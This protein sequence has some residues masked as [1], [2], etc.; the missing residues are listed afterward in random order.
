MFNPVQVLLYNFFSDSPAEDLWR[1]TSSYSEEDIAAYYADATVAASGV[2]KYDWESPMLTE[3]RHLDFN[4]DQHKILETELKMLYTA[5]T[6][7]RVNIFIAETDTDKSRPMFNYFQR[8]AVVDIR[9]H[10]E[11]L[12]GVRVFGAA[13]NTVEDWRNRGEFYLRNT[14]GE[15]QITCLR[16]AAKSA[17][18]RPE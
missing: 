15:R 3:T 11:E 8:R 9:D 13:L 7:A 4:A 1:V 18:I 12:S 16:L 2:Q 17:S 6:R 10:S 14:E 5:I